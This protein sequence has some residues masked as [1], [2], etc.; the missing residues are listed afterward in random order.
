MKF[1]TTM[2]ECP[3]NQ[4]LWRN[5]AWENSTL[6]I[7]LMNIQKS[8]LRIRLLQEIPIDSG[9]VI[10]TRIMQNTKI[11]GKIRDIFENHIYSGGN[12]SSRENEFC[13]EKYY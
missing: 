4:K 5:V 11:V 13:Y 1:Q 9:R 8:L 10:H 2:F 12:S 3:F 7:L 6:K